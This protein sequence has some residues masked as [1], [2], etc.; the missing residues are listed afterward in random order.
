MKK[1]E[2]PIIV[3]FPLRG[4][5]L[6]PNTPGTKIP[7][8][9]TDALGS[10][11]AYD[12]LQVD[13]ERKGRPNYRIHPLRYLFFG[14]KLTDCHCWGQNV[15]AP[16]DGQIIDAADGYNERSRIHILPDLFVAIKNAL[17]FDPRKDDLQ[18]VAGNYVIMR[19]SDNVY[20]ALVHFQRDSVRVSKGQYVKK[21][22]LLGNVGHS[23]NSTAPHLHFQLMDSGNMSDAKG[24]PCAFESYELFKD[25]EWKTINNGVPTNKDR[26]RFLKL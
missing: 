18:K 5:W 17:F 20:A 24:L 16:C 11:F 19:C 10:R 13:W 25:N 21:G 9:G 26:I 14:A 12:F 4:E 8:H 2:K 6:A 22:D 7:S 15:Y 3:E 23:G 1:I